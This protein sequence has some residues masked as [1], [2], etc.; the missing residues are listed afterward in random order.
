MF[1][2]GWTE[3]LLVAMVAIVVIPS[4]DLPK[5]LRT[6]GQSVG[7]LRR[8]A[9]EF[10]SQFNSALREAE[11]ETDLLEAKKQVESLRSLN[12]MNDV[13]KALN[14]LR[15]AGEDLKRD[16]RDAA[17]PMRSPSPPASD[18]GP[19][20][21]EPAKTGHAAD[22]PAPLPTVSVPMPEVMPATAPSIPTA[23]AAEPAP[24]S[25]KRPAE[26][27]PAKADEP[28]SQPPSEGASR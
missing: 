28:K 5:L 23:P 8:M 12:P 1:D 15:T 16:L 3:I 14:P 9:G 17:Q 4:K 20:A 2:I 10:Q 24:V 19:S 25:V 7:K 6:V 21:S 18:A 13:K 26:S 22:T 11:R 27:A